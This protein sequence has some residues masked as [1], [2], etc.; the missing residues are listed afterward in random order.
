M[1]QNQYPFWHV[2]QKHFMH[3]RIGKFYFAQLLGQH[4]FHSWNVIKLSRHLDYSNIT[5]V[6]VPEKKVK[7][8]YFVYL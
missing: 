6:S 7:L 8:Q 5:T 2:S 1:L 4:R 3:Q